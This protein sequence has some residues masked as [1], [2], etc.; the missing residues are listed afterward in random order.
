MRWGDGPFGLRVS[1]YN[2]HYPMIV[3][4]HPDHPDTPGLRLMPYLAAFGVGIHRKV[5]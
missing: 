2:R 1:T 4:R 3:L 5:F